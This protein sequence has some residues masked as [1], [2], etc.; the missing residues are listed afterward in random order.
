MKAVKDNV[1]YNLRLFA[2]YVYHTWIFKCFLIAL[3]LELILE[4]LGRRSIVEGFMFM[5]GSPFVFIYNTSIIFFTL[6][7]ALF[8]RKRVFGLIVISTVWLVCGT[9]NFV[10]L[11]YRVT[12]FAAIDVMMVKDV[13]SMIDV[14]FK[15][16]QLILIGVAA[17]VVIGLLI[18]LFLSTPRFS[19][20]KKLRLTSLVCLAAWFGLMGLTEL[21]IRNNIISDDFANLG[22]AY[23]DYGFAYCFTNSIIDNGIDEPD[24][25]SESSMGE[26][27]AELSSVDYPSPEK[28]PNVI[29]MQLES[30]FDPKAMAGV[31]FS[32]DPVPNFTKLKEQYPSGYF[33]VPAF[34]TGTAN[35][36]FEVLT[37]MKSSFFGAGEYPFKTTVNE[38]PS[39]TICS[40]LYGYG[41]G[42]YA[43]HNNVGSFYDRYNV[44]DEMGFDAFIPLE[45]MYNVEDTYNGWYK[46]KTLPD[47]IIRCLDDTDHQD[48]V[49]AITVQGHGRYPDEAGVCENHVM[50][51]YEDEDLQ[52]ELYYYI[53]QIYE[54]D[55]MIADLVERLDE[56]GEDY[57]LV[58]Y[59]DHLPTLI[60]DE[61]QLAYGDEF[62]TEYI[63]VNNI[64]LDIEDKDIMAYEI[65]TVLFEALSMEPGYAQK[66]QM[67]YS[68]VEEMEEKLEMIA[69]DMLYGEKYIYDGVIPVKESDMRYGV[70][71]IS[72]KDIYMEN[73]NMIVKGEG[74]NEYSIVYCDGDALDTTFVD[75]NT[76][77]VE[78]YEF[79]SDTPYCVTQ[80]DKKD[81]ERTSTPEY[82]K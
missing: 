46:D 80:V 47:D 39:E 55:M 68:D 26:I 12:P 41:Y 64:G 13:I 70:Q 74:F 38:T 35:T 18:F 21:S 78:E 8:L 19:G 37:G 20:D 48:F 60:T 62:Q 57:V 25:Y 59:G 31:Q 40:V 6:L 73:G 53:N 4:I 24:D 11:G 22:M 34:G 67:Y 29:F 1:L 10:V 43:M 23:E 45:Y 77:I 81:V 44:Y 2:V 36:E 71:N 33:T 32:E 65:S 27:K 63:I 16:W 30:F 58:L 75:F 52:N 14:Y 61:D 28:K 49:Y 69:Y 79:E 3:G 5:V 50:L 51:S 72:I 42:T 76:L 9:I 56:R 82:R 15:P 54:M 7:F 17:V 66:C